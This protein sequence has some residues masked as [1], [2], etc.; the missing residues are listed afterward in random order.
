ML[1]MTTKVAQSVGMP[2]RKS[3]LG[4][5]RGGT[6]NVTRKLTTPTAISLTG[7]SAAA[8]TI[9][10]TQTVT[11]TPVAFVPSQKISPTSDAPSKVMAPKKA[12]LG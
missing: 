12:V 2:S 1:G 8:N 11:A 10:P 9:A 6:N 4:N 5:T 7:T 3:S